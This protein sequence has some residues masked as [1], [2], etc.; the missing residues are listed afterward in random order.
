MGLRLGSG[1]RDRTELRTR[2]RLPSRRGLTSPLTHILAA[3]ASA[4]RCGGLGIAMH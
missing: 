3:T 2:V 4:F 1:I